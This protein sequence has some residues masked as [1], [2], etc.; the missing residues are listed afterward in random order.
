M[1]ALFNAC[2][3][4]QWFPLPLLHLV[5][6]RV[7]VT[8][9]ENVRIGRRIDIYAVSAREENFFS[10]EP[11][12]R[13]IFSFL[14]NRNTPFTSIWTA[15]GWSFFFIFFVSSAPNAIQPMFPQLFP[16]S[17]NDTILLCY[18]HT[19]TSNFPLVDP[20]LLAPLHFFNREQGTRS[21]EGS[22]GIGGGVQTRWPRLN[23]EIICFSSWTTKHAHDDDIGLNFTGI[24]GM[25]CVSVCWMGI[26]KKE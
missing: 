22:W 11:Q 20:S 7:V 9:T 17:P 21:G 2:H 5:D 15:V 26:R 18:I 12:K 25:Y 13:S 19:H 24:A 4:E 6:I 8:H 10:P 14:Q 23:S 1:Q 16:A 3:L